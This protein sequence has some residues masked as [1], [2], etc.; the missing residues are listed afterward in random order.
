MSAK[1][2]NISRNNEFPFIRLTEERKVYKDQFLRGIK[3]NILKILGCKL[4][5]LFLKGIVCCSVENRKGYLFP[6][7]VFSSRVAI[8]IGNVFCGFDILV[9]SNNVKRR[10]QI[11]SERE[12]VG[13][14]DM[15]TKGNN[16]YKK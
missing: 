4:S 12:I 16:R 5:F 2:T 10:T 13:R 7:S 9:Y 11:S 8:V 6:A 15:L 14:E 3:K 1:I